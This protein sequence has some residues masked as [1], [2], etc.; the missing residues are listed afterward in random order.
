MM[1][2]E[3]D[4][5]RKS[6][7][8]KSSSSSSLPLKKLPR[9]QP[10]VESVVTGAELKDILESQEIDPLIYFHD[11]PYYVNPKQYSTILMHRAMK[12]EQ[13]Y[14]RRNNIDPLIYFH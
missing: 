10:C 9:G 1:T 2:T 12:E 5:G 11:L 3:G 7:A 4:D 14:M 13:E 8:A 6:C